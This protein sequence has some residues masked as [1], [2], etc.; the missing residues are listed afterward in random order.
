MANALR[1]GD[2]ILDRLEVHVGSNELDGAIVLA[3]GGK[4]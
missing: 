4:R 3:S 2:H 1:V